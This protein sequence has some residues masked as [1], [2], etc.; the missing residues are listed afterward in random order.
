MSVV[1]PHEQLQPETL[2][3]L[4]EEFIT[5]DGAVHGHRDAPLDGMVE[6]VK[7]QLRAGKIFIVF[8]EED[9]TCT[10]VP[11]E[12]MGRPENG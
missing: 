6:S 9:E 5:R 2:L 3:A 1:V 10:L 8:D 11:A 12:E 4:I 7:R